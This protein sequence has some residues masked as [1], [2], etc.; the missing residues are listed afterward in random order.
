MHAGI[1]SKIYQK[2]K[3]DGCNFIKNKEYKCISGKSMPP[4]TN[5]FLFLTIST[6]NYI[7]DPKI[8]TKGAATVV[9]VR[10]VAQCSSLKKIVNST[11]TFAFACDVAV[12]PL[13][14]LFSVIRQTAIILKDKTQ[15]LLFHTRKENNSKSFLFGGIC[16]SWLF[17]LDMST[18]VRNFR[19]FVS[20]CILNDYCISEKSKNV[21]IK[22]V[23]RT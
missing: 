21:Y 3:S 2:K 19:F 5:L 7:S 12:V 6:K 15:F 17:S 9:F 4:Y 1:Q 13:H 16:K 18:D 20:S 11:H 23:K 8:S 10:K 22:Y 14:K